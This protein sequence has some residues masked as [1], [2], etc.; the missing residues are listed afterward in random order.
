M[1]T[2]L[3]RATYRGISCR[4]CGTPVRVPASILT[5]EVL[6]RETQANLEQT[7]CSSVFAQRCRSC[8]AEAIYSLQH[9]LEFEE[10]TPPDLEV[11][12]VSK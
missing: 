2:V 3:S 6:F 9:I 1:Q 10:E 11:A 8:G 7:W 4:S 12:N 5:R